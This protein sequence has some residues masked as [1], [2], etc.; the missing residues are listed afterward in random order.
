MSSEE[1]RGQPTGRGGR[2]RGF[3][4]RGRRGHGRGGRGRGRRDEGRDERRDEGRNEPDDASKQT[5]KQV[6]QETIS[7]LP[8]I[9]KDLPNIKAHD[10][11]LLSL[12]TLPSLKYC[13]KHGK[14]TV[15]VINEDTLNAAIML[16]DLIASSAALAT[17]TSNNGP[18]QVATSSRPA[19]L[20]FAS[21]TS[22]GGGFER[23]ALAQEEALCYR[24]SLFLS[25]NKSHYPW[26]PLQGLYT[27]DVVV[28]RSSIADGHALLGPDVPAADLLVVSVVSIAAICRPKVVDAQTAS[29]ETRKVFK[30]P[31]DRV[32]TKDKMRL[33]LRMAASKGHDS[34]VLGALGCGAYRNPIGEIVNAWKEVLEDDEFAGGWWRNVWFAIFD[35]DNEGSGFKMF[36]NVLGGM[37]V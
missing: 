19:I 34:I 33:A 11:E 1:D 37:E 32:L 20:N 2:S 28:I 15:N 7:V 13:P 27:R 26:T 18:T 36:E 9:L 25:L 30:Q 35:P 23:G 4:A 17:K 3:W 6:G 14:A 10:S 22:P 16:K 12:D 21:D 31:D 5:L 8:F 24:S 29:G